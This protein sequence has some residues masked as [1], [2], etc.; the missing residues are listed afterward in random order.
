MHGRTWTVT[1]PLGV[2]LMNEASSDLLGERDFSG[3]CKKNERTE[4][5]PNCCVV[6]AA[7]MPW[8]MGIAFEIVAD[9][10]MQGMI[11]MIVG[12]VVRIGTGKIP[13]EYVKEILEGAEDR[14]AGPVAP[15][16][17]LHLVNVNYSR[18]G[19][20]ADPSRH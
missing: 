11:R 12:T 7:W 4:R 5:N 16:K 10:F 18:V 14:R 1:R 2:K 20:G 9:R 17:G 3:F 6:S 13:P 15:A 8:D 19:G